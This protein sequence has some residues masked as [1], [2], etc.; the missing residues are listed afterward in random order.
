MRLTDLRLSERLSPRRLGFVVLSLP[1]VAVVLTIV[2]FALLAQHYYSASQWVA[3][4]L[5]VSAVLSRFQDNLLDAQM[6]VRGYVFTGEESF[7]EPYGAGQSALR[8]TLAEL[9][10]LVPDNPRQQTQLGELQP[11]LAREL[12]LFATLVAARAAGTLS[13]EDQRTLVQQTKSEMDDLRAAVQ[14]MQAQEQ[15]LTTGKA[16][17]G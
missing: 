14:S 2:A 10:S 6:A 8:A 13:A 11:R 15:R 1:L 17:R 9:E 7:L 4:T 16:C 12:D 3:H 5:E